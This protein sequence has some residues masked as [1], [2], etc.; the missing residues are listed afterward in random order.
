VADDKKIISRIQ[1]RK[2]LKADLPLPLRPGEFG[3]AVDSR[4]LY[5]GGDTTDPL[6][7]TFNR[8]LVF[9][10]T[11]S[12]KDRAEQLADVAVVR[13]TVPH[14]RFER[15][16]FDGISRTADW[17]PTSPSATGSVL[18]V[19]STSVT[20]GANAISAIRSTTTN[21]AFRA[22]DLTVMRSGTLLEGDNTNPT[23]PSSDKDYVFESTVNSTNFHRI[24][25]R[26]P[27][28]PSDS[29]TV[30]YYT[31]E[32]V[33]N[34]LSASVI[35][36]NS[37]LLGFYQAYPDIPEYRRLDP[38][39]IT[40]S[41]TS[42]VGFVGFDPKQLAVYVG[43]SLPVADPEDLTLGNLLCVRLSDSVGSSATTNATAVAITVGPNNYDPSGDFPATFVST[44]STSWLNNK[45]LEVSSVAG[46]TIIADLPIQDYA[47]GRE[48]VSTQISANVLSLT[49]NVAGVSTGDTVFFVNPGGNLN[50]ISSVVSGVSSI[51]NGVGSFLVPLNDVGNIS[52]NLSYINRGNIAT[53]G[54]NTFVQVF[55]A[56]HGYPEGANTSFLTP[57][58]INYTVVGPV[59]NNTFYV[60]AGSPVTTVTVGTMQPNVSGETYTDEEFSAAPVRAID[61]SGA[62]TLVNAVATVNTV[63]DWPQLSFVPGSLDTVFFT[64]KNSFSSTGLE[65]RLFEDTAGT[66]DTLRLSP[67]FAGFDTTV[68]AKFERWI[69]NLVVDSDI[70]LFTSAQSNQPYAASGVENLGTWTLDVDETVNELRFSSR[71][72]AANFAKTLNRAYF[73]S[74]GA[75]VRGLVTLKTNI[76]LATRESVQIG[77]ATTS[78]NSPRT[79]VISP[80]AIPV[81]VANFEVDLNVFNNFVIEYSVKST[82]VVG[83]FY[84]RTGQLII[85]AD[86]RQ[87]AGNG[88]VALN[89]IAA[90]VNEGFTGTVEFDAIISNGLITLD[91]NNTLNPGTAVRFSYI[92]RRWK[93]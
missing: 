14:I 16:T 65:F 24:T 85:T 48:V 52:A 29:L 54:S 64:H 61:L 10:N 72:E 49:G 82:G 56:S 22:T 66:L 17:L 81:T 57:S 62:N 39:L 70:T 86:M 12:A 2:G 20:G 84:T 42:G 40:V 41:P 74:S 27:F 88:A 23:V 31:A 30:T 71:H 18:P 43:G 7:D 32:N 93:D 36:P 8:S 4:Q 3:F 9:E 89:D 44:A 33:A 50:N 53:L 60:D 5:I 28:A 1:Q 13:F 77:T 6:A 68:K 37:P 45:L 58:A 21:Q 46:S 73:Q 69:N 83:E 15:G 67:G 47:T 87:N 25:T 92:A 26:T 75:D 35:S 19:F 80:S 78:Y 91:L 76:E 11:I 63:N 38:E 55:S 51:Q 34:S 59:T 79:I 90:E